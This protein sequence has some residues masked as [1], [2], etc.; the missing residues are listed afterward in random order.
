MS[1]SGKTQKRYHATDWKPFTHHRSKPLCM[2]RVYHDHLH[3]FLYVD[4]FRNWSPQ[5]FL[6]LHCGYDPEARG[7]MN[8]TSR[9]HRQVCLFFCVAQCS[10]LISS[11]CQPKIIMLVLE[12]LIAMWDNYILSILETLPWYKRGLVSNLFIL[13]NHS[14]CYLFATGMFPF[15]I[16]ITESEAWNEL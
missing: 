9:N 11:F 1:L 4:L 16:L 15:E 6:C 5:T 10:Y 8:M 13:L 2:D 3:T 7:L 12:K 14:S